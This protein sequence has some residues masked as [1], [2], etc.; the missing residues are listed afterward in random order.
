MPHGM[1]VA[2]KLR[3]VKEV[4]VHRGKNEWKCS[5]W[6]IPVDFVWFSL[7]SQSFMKLSLPICFLLALKGVKKCGKEEEKHADI[8]SYIFHTK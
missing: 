6:L 8:E 4:K 1:R 7:C 3:K 2:R 5:D